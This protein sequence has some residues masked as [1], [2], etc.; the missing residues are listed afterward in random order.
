MLNVI[1]HL[2]HYFSAEIVAQLPDDILSL[3]VGV[4]PHTIRQAR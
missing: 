4:F 1:T 3:L 2:E